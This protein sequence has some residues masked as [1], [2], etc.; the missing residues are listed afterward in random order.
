MAN[1]T[2][3]DLEELTSDDVNKARRAIEYY[4]DKGWTDGL[5]IVP[6]IESFVDEFLAHT[7]RSPDEVILTQDRGCRVHGV[8]NLFIMGS[9]VFPTVGHANPTLLIVG[10]AARLAQQ[11]RRSEE[12]RGV[13]L[14]LLAAMP[15]TPR[16]QPISR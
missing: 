1:T 3:I 13:D 2:D 10:L 12:Q 4:Y 16:I 11:I 15:S 6:P 9:S 14:R 5:P 8:A 7:K